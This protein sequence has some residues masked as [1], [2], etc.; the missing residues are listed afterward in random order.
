MRRRFSNL[1]RAF[2]WMTVEGRSHKE[3][4]EMF[5]RKFDNPITET[6]VKSFIHNNRLNTGKTGYFQKGNPP[7]NK[8][9][10]GGPSRSPSTCFKKGHLPSMYRPAGSVRTDVDGYT[11]VKVADPNKWK[12]KHVLVYEQAYGKVPPGKVVIFGDG[13]KQNF[14]LDNL[15]LV[16]RAE[17]LMLNKFKL[18]GR[19]AELTRIGT[20]TADLIMTMRRKEKERNGKG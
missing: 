9:I 17:L 1:E 20:A 10:T 14:E 3:I 5:N 7:Y 2:L 16:S 15:V 6:Q 18:I 4:A 8:G 12:M 11:L 19:S 13:D